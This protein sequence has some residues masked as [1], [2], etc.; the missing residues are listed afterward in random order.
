MNIRGK[1]TMAEQAW[2][3]INQGINML[4]IAVQGAK[5]EEQFTKFLIGSLRE[6]I[7]Y[8]SKLPYSFGAF[9]N[10]LATENDGCVELEEVD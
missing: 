4:E 1:I 6:R 9:Y 10:A 7:A 3:V 5:K 8:N 2:Q